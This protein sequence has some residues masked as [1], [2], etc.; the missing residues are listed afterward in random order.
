MYVYETIKHKLK[1]K[2]EVKVKYKKCLNWFPWF[3]CI[4]IIEN[5]LNLSV[6]GKF[7]HNKTFNNKHKIIF[8][9][10]F[11]LKSKIIIKKFNMKK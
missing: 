6:D 2:T 3:V 9:N 8:L 7:N 10:K 4:V 11:S 5:K 1:S